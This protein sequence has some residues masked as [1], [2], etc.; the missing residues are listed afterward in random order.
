MGTGRVRHTQCMLGNGLVSNV[1]LHLLVLME[2]HATCT[3]LPLNCSLKNY[4]FKFAPTQKTS[5]GQQGCSQQCYRFS[6]EQS[7]GSVRSAQGQRCTCRKSSPL[8]LGSCCI[9][10]SYFIHSLLPW[11]FLPTWLPFS[12]PS[13]ATYCKLVLKKHNAWRQRETQRRKT[14][15][16]L[17]DICP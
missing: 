14:E 4:K 2:A 8:A 1:A 5:K 13:Q 9:F 7:R 3:H 15:K 17:A 10:R 16:P 12:F 6:T 11:L